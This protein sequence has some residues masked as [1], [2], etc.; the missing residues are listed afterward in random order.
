MKHLPTARAL[1]AALALGLAVSAWSCSALGFNKPVELPPTSVEQTSSGI[2]WVDLVAGTGAPIAAGERVRLHYTAELEG[3]VVFDSSEERGQP[4]EL[5]V[6]AGEV[7]PGWDDGMLG[8]RP[9]G[10]RRLRI[11]PELAYGAAG[12]ADVVP[13]NSTLILYVEMLARVEEVAE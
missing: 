1:R 6:G 9:G 10:R 8:M 4:V 2:E 5:T 7:V 13:P 3:G 12:Y 11:P